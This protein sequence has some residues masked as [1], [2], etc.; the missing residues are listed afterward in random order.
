MSDQPNLVLEHLRAIRSD[1]MEIKAD[2]REIKG[3]LIV[4]EIAYGSLSSRIDRVGDDIELI[5][6]RLELV[7]AEEI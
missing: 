7:D 2:V 1:V 3:R 5:K 6:H 4:L